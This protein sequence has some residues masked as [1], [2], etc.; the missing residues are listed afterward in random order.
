MAS[1][2][3]TD[4]SLTYCESSIISIIF[5]YIHTDICTYSFKYQHCCWAG[6]SQTERRS[7]RSVALTLKGKG[8]QGAPRVLILSVWLTGFQYRSETATRGRNTQKWQRDPKSIFQETEKKS[9]FLHCDRER[10]VVLTHKTLCCLQ[11]EHTYFALAEV[12]TVVSVSLVLDID[13][14]QAHVFIL[15]CPLVIIFLLQKLMSSELSSSH[16]TF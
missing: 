13:V 12:I 1:L 9:R 7:H 5:S 8:L 11:S 6:W 10:N 16:K 15:L 14:I 2:N 4:H 3:M